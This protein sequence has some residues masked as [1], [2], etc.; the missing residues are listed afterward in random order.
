MKP[1]VLFTD[2]AQEF[3]NNGNFMYGV[4]ASGKKYA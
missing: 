4:D 1:A 3:W 2:G